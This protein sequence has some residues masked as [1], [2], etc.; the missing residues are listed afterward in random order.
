[1]RLLLD[2]PVVIWALED[3]PKLPPA[4]RETISEAADVFVS[5]ATTWEMAI[6]KAAGKLTIADSF[7]QSI[8]A[9]GFL[10]LPIT[11]RHSLRAAALP[12]HHKDPFDRMLVAQA[13]DENL[14]LMTIDGQ[15][16]D[17]DVPLYWVA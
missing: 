1:M 8:A 9:S 4:A 12:A 2:T 7:A 14:T 13:Q 10:E 11:W 5:S 16:P 15:L 6:K 17:Y 3:N